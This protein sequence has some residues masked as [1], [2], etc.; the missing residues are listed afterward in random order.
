MPKAPITQP[1]SVRLRCCD[2]TNQRGIVGISMAYS[3]CGVWSLIAQQLTNAFVTVIMQWY[4]VK[5]RPQWLFD[6]ERI[7]VLFNFGGKMFCSSFLDTL[8]NDI[9]S[10]VIGKIS[11]LEMLSYYDRGKQY[12]KLG[13]DIINSTIGSVFLTAFSELQDDCPKMKELANL[14]L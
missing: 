1:V 2:D 4:W 11:D 10:L 14:G 13:M 7:K 3:D 12:P 8:Y 5:W 9:Y 6:W